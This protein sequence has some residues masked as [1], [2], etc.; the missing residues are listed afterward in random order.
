MEGTYPIIIR[1]EKC[2]ELCVSKEGAYTRFLARCPLRAEV[3]RLCVYGQGKEGYLGVPL[4]KG[5]ELVLDKRFSPSSMK[6]FPEKI[7]G[8]TLAGEAIVK[9]PSE[10]QEQAPDAEEPAPCVEKAEEEKPTL[11][12]ATTDGALV[13][14]DGELEMVALP[15]EDE[16]VPKD[17]PG[18]PRV[19]DGKEY[20]VYITREMSDP[21]H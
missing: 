14:K 18:Q 10:K 2:G 7:E 11:W 1:R 9:L 15:P 6:L 19:I 5:E 16:R 13:S 21:N 3:I 12:Y 20:L 8:C 17:F 4:P